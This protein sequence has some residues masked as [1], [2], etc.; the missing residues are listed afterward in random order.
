MTPSP[1][2]RQRRV[3]AGASRA[4]FRS[5]G[6]R[7]WLA[8]AAHTSCAAKR[9]SWAM[10]SA[11]RCSEGCARALHPQPSTLNPQPSIL[12]PQS[13]SACRLLARLQ[14]QL[15]E[16]FGDDVTIVT[17]KW[18]ENCAAYKKLLEP[19]DEH[20]LQEWHAMSLRHLP[21]PKKKP[22]SG[23]HYHYHYH[24]TR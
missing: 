1:F 11:C 10:P 9:H 21:V 20:T 12:N 24:R 5:N 6:K 22:E 13:S 14:E 15:R 16:L 8:G 3:R 18:V 2:Q 4:R 23:G 19:P 7:S 17:E